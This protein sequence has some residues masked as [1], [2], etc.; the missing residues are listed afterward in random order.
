MSRLVRAQTTRD[1]TCLIIEWKIANLS[2][3]FYERVIVSP[4][5]TA[6]DDFTWRLEIRP[7]Y[8]KGSELWL[9]HETGNLDAISCS[10]K[11]DILDSNGEPSWIWKKM[12]W[13]CRNFPAVYMP[14]NSDYFQCQ[15][16]DTFTFRV[17]LTY[18]PVSSTRCVL[19]KDDCGTENQ[20]TPK[21]EP[22]KCTTDTTHLQ[23]G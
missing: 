13:D 18:S 5:F 23:Q 6:G 2:L 17:E 16:N 12:P 11:A 15:E 21:A 1:V 4:T 7:R 20:L 19:E 22:V 8:R 10:I 9:L 14:F 3:F